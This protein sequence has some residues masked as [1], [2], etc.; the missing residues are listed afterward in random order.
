VAELQQQD[1][2]LP[3]ADNSI[4]A[5]ALCIAARYGSMAGMQAYSRQGEA[6]PSVHC[7]CQTAIQNCRHMPP[8]K[9]SGPRHAILN[10]AAACFTSCSWLQ[11]APHPPLVD[12]CELTRMRFKQRM[13]LPPPTFTRS[14][15]YTLSDL[16]AVLCFVLLRPPASRSIP[17][18]Q[19]PH[20]QSPAACIASGA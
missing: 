17:C 19:Q 10:A 15:R 11:P 13:A 20:D 12:V 18:D 8:P 4:P 3:G 9:L 6:L 7:C 1:L 5:A 2:L 14:L 16:G